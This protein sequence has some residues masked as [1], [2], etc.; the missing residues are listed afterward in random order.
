MQCNA[1]QYN[2]I[3]YD[4]CSTVGHNISRLAQSQRT[5]HHSCAH[6]VPLPCH[7]F[8]THT[9]WPALAAVIQLCVCTG[10]G[11]HRLLLQIGP[12]PVVRDPCLRG[13]RHVA[14]MTPTYHRASW[15][16]STRCA[17]YIPG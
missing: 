7:V 10:A 15:I 4:Q 14:R 5:P 9:R 11:G 8:G 12:S 2:T 17:S 6:S 3:Q 13:A 16:R 1:M